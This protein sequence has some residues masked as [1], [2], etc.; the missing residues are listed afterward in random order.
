MQIQLLT[1]C[2]RATFLV[3]LLLSMSVPAQESPAGATAP[4]DAPVDAEVISSKL[5][6]V[7]ASTTLSDEAA[8]TLVDLYRRALTNLK[9]AQ[10]ERAD[11]AAIAAAGAGAPQELAAVNRALDQRRA[12]AP[13][14][15]ASIPLE[16]ALPELER[17]LTEERALL[18]EALARLAEYRQR[19][20]AE[21]ARP[22]TAR[23]RL[24]AANERQARTAA[25]LS[26]PAPIGESAEL[27]E[28]RRWQLE[29]RAYRLAAE[30]SK[31]DQEL[32]THTARLELLQARQDLET[33]A[34]EEAT[35]K[36]RRLEDAINERRGV[37][38]ELARLEATAAEQ[39]L[40]GRHATI[41]ELAAGNV[42]LSQKQAA[43]VQDLQRASE[44]RDA[45][46]LEVT[47]IS[48]E[49]SSTQSRLAIAGVNQTLGQILI[50]HR[51]AL[52]NR[53]ALRKRAKQLR[54]QVA[55]AGLEQYEL[56]EQRRNLRN[57]ESFVNKL[58]SDIVAEDI[59]EIRRELRT[60]AQVRR[61][62][63]R[64]SVD[65]GARYLRI[66]SELDLA[67]RQLEDVARDYDEFLAQRLLWIRNTQPIKVEALDT[68]YA[69]LQRMTSASGWTQFAQGLLTSLQARPY[70]AFAV[71]A[72]LLLAALR[73]RVLAAIETRAKSVGRIR[74][75]RFR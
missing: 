56:T 34:V 41:R 75:D 30:I 45:V 44:E 16:V 18:S 50:Q 53:D 24:E 42:E 60:L 68:F 74:T 26:T 46:R 36:T 63:V 4:V 27:S 8:A 58:A 62:L 43:Q 20:A 59:A 72:L 38:A 67:A 55:A 2:A 15:S 31:L 49:M 14:E 69:D 54:D 47:R 10:A 37:A 1:T 70:L 64:K 57:I 33:A 52:P 3:L 28:A 21:V 5:A 40:E 7:E 6:E 17:S 19:Y 12:A 29:T 23:Q 9:R 48:E 11:A 65:T 66:L 22:E 39:A 71:I 13:E 73:N 61:D 35:A 32:L 25:E 51:R